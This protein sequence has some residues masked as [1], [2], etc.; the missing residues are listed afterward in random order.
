VSHRDLAVDLGTANTLVFQQGRGVVYDE[1]TVVA[2]NA[3]S[4]QVLAAGSKAWRM[5]SES[6]G[7]V[8]VVRPLERGVIADFEMTASMLRLIMR[9]LGVTRFPRPRALVCVPASSTKVERRAVEEAVTS[10]GL[11]SATLVEETLAAAVGAGLPIHE[12]VGSLVVDIG[13]GTTEVAV[14][15][16]GGIVTGSSMPVGGFDLDAAIQRYIRHR[17]GVAIGDRSAERVKVELGSAY[18]AADTAPL[19]IRGRDMATAVPAVLEI[20]PEEIRECLREPVS[21]MVDATK[22]CLADAPAELAHDVLERGIFLTGGSG[23]LRGLDMRLSGECEVPVH[24][25]ERPLETVVL[26]AG[27][28]LEYMPDYRSAF[29]AASR[30]A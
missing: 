13:G 2:V 11:R 4:G 3:R 19:S 21:A 18:P 24:L 12:P 9:S 7:N 26:G 5:L 20:S 10:A 25:T 29:V 17:Y 6:P 16:M 30:W 28:L 8:Q 14:V 27:R 15:A 23:L 22:R 1:P